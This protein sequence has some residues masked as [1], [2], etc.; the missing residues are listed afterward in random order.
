MYYVYL[1]KLST[2]EPYVGSTPNLQRRLR[3]H[4]RGNCK[5]TKGALPFVLMSYYC[6]RERMIALR[7]ERYLKSGSGRAFRVRHFG[8]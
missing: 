1:L 7:F 4:E 6:F 5:S 3:E 2:G 8:F